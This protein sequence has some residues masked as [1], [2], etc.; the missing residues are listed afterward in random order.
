MDSTCKKVVIVEGDAA[1]RASL[2]TAMETSGYMA[3]SSATARDGL[4]AL[5][6]SNADLLLLDANVPDLS[7]LETLSA[8]RGSPVTSSVRVIL[9]VG[10]SANER[11]TAIEMGA[12]DAVSRPWELSELLARVREQCR[13]HG[14]EQQLRDKARLAEEGQQVAYTAFDAVAVTEKRTNDA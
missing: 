6:R 12:N 14:D 2:Q 10:P 3:W 9:L 13:T 1:T 8:I 11:T 5:S 4:E 7:P